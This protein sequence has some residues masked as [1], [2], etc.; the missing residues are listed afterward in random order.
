M[1]PRLI[2]DNENRHSFSELQLTFLKN[3][4]LWGKT[5]C[6]VVQGVSDDVLPLKYGKLLLTWN[7][8]PKEVS[9]H[10][11]RCDSFGSYLALLCLTCS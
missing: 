7:C 1:W 5:V 11:H 2:A 6:G 4:A 10:Y 3:F 8:A 9:T